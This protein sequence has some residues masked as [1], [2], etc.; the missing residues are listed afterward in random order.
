MEHR[1]SERS[2]TLTAPLRAA[3]AGRRSRSTSPWW[4]GSAP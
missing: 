4:P 2:P 3:S 1:G